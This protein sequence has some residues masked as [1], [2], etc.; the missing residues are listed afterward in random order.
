MEKILDEKY[1][2]LPLKA[3]HE[4]IDK[5]LEFRLKN[6]LPELMD[7]AQIDMWIVAA[8]EYNE[9]PVFMT[10]IPAIE[11]TASRLSCFIFFLDEN[12]NMECLSVCRPNAILEKYYK[13][14]WNSEAESQ[15]ECV[16]RIVESRSPNKVGVNIS[17][18]FALADG[19]TKT[20]YEE[21][22]K[23]LGSEYT[24]L[25]VS[26]EPLC[27]S[28]LEIRS[29]LELSIYPSIYKVAEDIIEEA[30][31]KDVIEVG[32]TTTNDIEWWMMQKINDLGL[33]AWFTPTIDLQRKG[34]ENP[35]LSDTLI[36]HGDI[37][38]CDIGIE[39][40][41]LCTDTQRIAYVLKED[42]KSAPT[43]I[44]AALHHCNHFQDLVSI[45]FIEGRTGNQVLSAALKEANRQNMKAMCYTHPIGYHGHGAGPIIG[46]WD[47]QGVVP[48]RGDYTL[49]KDTCYALELNSSLNVD[50]WDG[51]EVTI[52]LEETV[53]FTK[54]GIKYIGNSQTEFI[55]I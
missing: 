41:S 26:A 45:N 11:K 5:I 38:H 42:E 14:E 7:K 46:L 18:N 54:E 44:K 21:L 33:K 52:F 48:I 20:L 8:R 4:F 24:N 27:I 43:G 10:L 19:L 50:E 30:F 1:K 28:W 12:K 25:I 47:N 15:W 53:A 55:L 36:C 31:S 29:L 32:K 3:Q 9:D 2:I 23:A 17:K 49:N 51:Q 13:R 6:I 39:Y 34:E 37:L 35:R 16:K 40:M 22:S